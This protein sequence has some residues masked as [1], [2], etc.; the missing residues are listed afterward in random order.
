MGHCIS[1]VFFLR[2]RNEPP[3]DKGKVPWLG[4]ALE[5]GKDAAKFLTLM[6]EKHAD[7]FTVS[8]CQSFLYYLFSKAPLPVHLC[9]IWCFKD[10]VHNALFQRMN[11]NDHCNYSL[12]NSFDRVSHSHVNFC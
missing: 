2:Q 1:T 10:P 6:K 11:H 8:F 12:I 3:L 4:H 5:F 9:P 7:I